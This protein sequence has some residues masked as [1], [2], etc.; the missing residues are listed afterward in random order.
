MQFHNSGTSHRHPK[1]RWSPCYISC[2][3]MV[4]FLD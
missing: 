2:T 4:K 3:R 1:Q